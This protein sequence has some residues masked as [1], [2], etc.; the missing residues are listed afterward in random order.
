METTSSATPLWNYDL[1]TCPGSVSDALSTFTDWRQS[2]AAVGGPPTQVSMW[3]LRTACFQPEVGVSTTVGVSWIGGIRDENWGASVCSVFPGDW[4]LV[5]HEIGHVFG[6]LHPFGTND[7]LIGKMGSIMDYSDGLY[8]PDL[9]DNT[10]APGALY[11]FH[12]TNHQ[13][14]C[15][16]LRRVF[17][18][19]C[20]TTCVPM[21]NSFQIVTQECGNGIVES[22]ETC[23]D[24]FGLNGAKNSCCSST[25]QRKPN[26]LCMEYNS[27]CCNQCLPRLTQKTCNNGVGYCGVN[28]TCETS[29][30]SRYGLTLCPLVTSAS[31][32]CVLQCVWNGDCYQGVL[33]D[34]ST[35]QPLDMRVVNGSVC[36]RS[37]L[38]QCRNGVC[39]SP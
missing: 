23:D 6:A 29:I 20:L 35:G 12:P 36:Q 34:S 19:Q 8:P 1:S 33:S 9:P 30:C 14:V 11:Q 10:P 25:C 16:T 38:K 7:S 37:P 39:L 27:D 5:S 13:Q 32:P 31:N 18:N 3:Q 17:A 28:G 15:Q 4:V 26:S 22:P 21:E 2:A 24:G